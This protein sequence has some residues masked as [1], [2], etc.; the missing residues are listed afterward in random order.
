ML[1]SE[2][3]KK[4]GNWLSRGKWRLG[5]KTVGDEMRDEGTQTEI[6]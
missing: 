3:G 4:L 6:I 1:N 5:S 2:N